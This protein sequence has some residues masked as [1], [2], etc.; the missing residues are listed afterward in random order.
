[1]L[2]VKFSCKYG[3]LWEVINPYLLALVVPQIK[4]KVQFCTLFFKIYADL[5]Q[6]RKKK[7]LE[8]TMQEE[9]LKDLGLFSLEKRLREDISLQIC[10][11]L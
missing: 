8:Y 9:K 5:V 10:K 11:M 2:V 7:S 6:R 4:N 1:M 3:V